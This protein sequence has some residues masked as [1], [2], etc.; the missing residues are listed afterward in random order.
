MSGAADSSMKDSCTKGWSN[1]HPRSCLIAL[2]LVQPRPTLRM[3]NR[4]RAP[5]QATPG[6]E[7]F[8]QGAW[9]RFWIRCLLAKVADCLLNRQ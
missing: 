7:G 3:T 1:P 9:A 8:S 5:M 4:C 2:R 6:E